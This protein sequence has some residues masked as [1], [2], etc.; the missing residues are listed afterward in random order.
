MKIQNYIVGAV[1]GLS[2][3]LSTV[4][5]ALTNKYADYKAQVDATKGTVAGEVAKHR[6][7]F[8]RETMERSG[9]G[10]TMLPSLG[11]SVGA[12]TSA[13]KYLRK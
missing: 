13:N 9:M 5:H 11:E 8:C 2:L 4:S 12:G 10:G 6:G 3:G 1:F 7:K